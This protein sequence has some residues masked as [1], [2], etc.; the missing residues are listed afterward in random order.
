MDYN[1]SQQQSGM[2]EQAKGVAETAEALPT[3][4]YLG[5]VFGS[6]AVSALL[7]LMGKKSAAVF[8]GLW[9]PTLLNLAM[10]YKRLRPSQEF[11]AL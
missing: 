3:N 6:M 10:V 1:V 5:G 4:V 2:Q 11:N 8:V 9:P 7:F